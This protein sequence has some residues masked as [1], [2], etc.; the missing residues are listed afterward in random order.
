MKLFLRHLVEYQVDK[1]SL[2]I[3]LR[4]IHSHLYI[5]EKYER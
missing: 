5:F 1:R 4:F 2:K 3:L